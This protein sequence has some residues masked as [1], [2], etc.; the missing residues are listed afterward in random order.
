MIKRGKE[1]AGSAGGCSALESFSPPRGAFQ[2]I[3]SQPTIL[4]IEITEERQPFDITN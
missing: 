1:A 3:Q 4:I 2:Q